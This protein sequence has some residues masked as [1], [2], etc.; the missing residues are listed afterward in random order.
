MGKLPDLFFTKTTIGNLNI[1]RKALKLFPFVYLLISLVPIVITMASIVTQ[2]A[3]FNLL[4]LIALSAFSVF[5]F[6]IRR[7]VLINR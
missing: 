1:N 2:F 6:V 3:I 4:L 7:K 5:T